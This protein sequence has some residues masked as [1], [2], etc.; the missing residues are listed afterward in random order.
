MSIWSALSN[1]GNDLTINIEGCFDYSK[2][3]EF[4]D[5]YKQIK[6]VPERYT[7]NMKETISLDNS[8]LGVLL[9]LRDHAGNHSD[10]IRII[11]C[12]E[13]VKDIFSTCNFEQLFAIE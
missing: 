12:N 13:S 5:A 7:I 2:H 1:D 4:L 11:N 8:A 9:M 10:N 3:L 6:G